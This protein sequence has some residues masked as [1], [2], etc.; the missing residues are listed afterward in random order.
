MG[1]RAGKRIVV[2]LC[3]VCR[4]GGVRRAPGAAPRGGGGRLDGGGTLWRGP[5][6]GCAA[7][8]AAPGPVGR[9]PVAASGSLS[10]PRSRSS[11]AGAA[12]SPAG[13]PRLPAGLAAAPSPSA[14]RG[15]P[16]L[17]CRRWRSAPSA[18]SA[19]DLRPERGRARRTAS[20]PGAPRRG[21]LLGAARARAGWPSPAGWWARL[22][23]A[24]ASGPRRALGVRGGGGGELWA[25]PPRRPPPPSRPAPAP[26]GGAIRRPRAPKAAVPGVPGAPAGREVLAGARQKLQA[27]LDDPQKLDAVLRGAR[28]ARLDPAARC[29]QIDL[30]GVPREGTGGRPGEG[31]RVLGLPLPV[32]PPGWPA[33]FAFVPQAGGRVAVYFKNYPLDAL[34]PEAAPRPPTRAP[35]SSPWAR[36]ARTTRASSRPTTTGCSRPS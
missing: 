4:G 32:L 33:P 22:A 21:P 13:L 9:A 12:R 28:R 1:S 27:T 20:R 7:S 2:A 23:V 8:P 15:A 36:S 18:G 10:T 16:A 26:D 19:P 35:A 17:G 31:G 30:A 5:A 29:Y 14:A 34:Q 11:C 25:R 3:S 6:S 24:P